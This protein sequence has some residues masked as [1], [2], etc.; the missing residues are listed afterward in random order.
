VA[1]LQQAWD[2]MQKGETLAQ[3]AAHAPGLRRAIEFFGK[4]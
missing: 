1:S 4:K 2:A 3:R